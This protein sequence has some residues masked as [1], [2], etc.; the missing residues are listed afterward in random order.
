MIKPLRANMMPSQGKVVYFTKARRYS[1]DRRPMIEP[2]VKPFGI[3]TF[4]VDEK[5]RIAMAEA[6]IRVDIVNGDLN[7]VVLRK[8]SF[9]LSKL[10]TFEDEKVRSNGIRY[11]IEDVGRYG[12]PEGLGILKM[13]YELYGRCE[14]VLD[15]LFHVADNI[16]TVR[17]MRILLSAY[18][19]KPSDDRL[20]GLSNFAWW[21]PGAIPRMVN[22]MDASPLPNHLSQ[23]ATDSLQ[24]Y[25]D[26]IPTS[27]SLAKAGTAV[28]PE[29]E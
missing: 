25:V 27:E 1:Y 6:D 12:E 14:G 3:D 10:G 9:A 22:V 11:L 24:R 16:G 19:S 18:L 21:F 4:G 17:G 23:M 8:I 28:C 15:Q 26:T 7:L 2:P 13:C 5:S 20:E 29:L